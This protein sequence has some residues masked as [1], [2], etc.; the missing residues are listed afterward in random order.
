VLPPIRADLLGRRVLEDE[1]IGIRV[2]EPPPLSDRRRLEQTAELRNIAP[3]WT[4]AVSSAPQPTTTLRKMDIA[5]LD[6]IALIHR[7]RT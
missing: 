6:D 1:A 5:V 2:I 7:L 3:K 4:P